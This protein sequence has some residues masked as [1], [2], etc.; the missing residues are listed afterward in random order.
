MARGARRRRRARR[1]RPR[2]TP[3]RARRR[4]RA[5]SR[6][7]ALALGGHDA[8]RE[9]DP[10]AARAAVPGRPRRSSAASA[11][12]SAGTRSRRCSRPTRSPRSSAATS[13]ATSRPRR[14]TRSA[15]TTSGTRPSDDAR[16][17]PRLHPGPLVAGHL[18]ARLPRGPAH[19]RSSCAASARR[20]GRRDGRSRS[21][22]HPWLMPDFW[23]FPT[24]SMGL[25][26]IMA[27]YQARF[28]K[29]L[30]GRGLADTAGRK[31]WAFLG[32]GETDEPE[33][34]GAI[35][36][37]GREHL[38][39][40]D[41]RRQLQ[42][43]AP[44][45]PGARQRQDHPGARDDLPRRGLE[46]HQGDLGLALGP[47]ARRR[48]RGPAACSAWRR[49]ST[50]TTRPTSR[51]TAPTCASTSSAP[52]PELREMVAHMT[53]EEIWALNR[54]GHDP[55]KVYAAYAAA[56]EHTG[57]A[58]GDPRQDDQGLRDGRGRRGPEHHP[59][60]EEDGRGRAAARSAT[61]SS[62]DAHRRAGPRRARST[63][64]PTTRRRWSYLRERRAALGGG[65]PA[66][67][68]DAPAAARCPELDAVRVASSRAPASARS[69]RRWRS[70]AILA[71]LLRDKKIGKH[72]VPI[73]PDE[74]RTFGMEGM[75][76]QLGIFS[77]VGQLYQPE[78]ADQLMF[79]REDK[80]GQVLQE[81]I[82][83]AGAFSSWIAAAHVVLQPRRADDPVLHLLLDV[84]LPAGRRPRL[85]RGRQPRAR[86]PARRHRGAHDAERRGPPARGRPLAHPQRDDPELRLLRPDVRL[87]G[88]RDRPG[89][90]AAHAGRA[91][92]RL[93]LPHAHERELP[94]PGDARG[95]ARR[96]SSRAC[97]CCAEA[98]GDGPQ[99]QL[100][101]SGT[102]LREVLAGAELL[103]EDFGVAADVW[104]VTSFTELRRDG[105]RGR[106]LE[107]AAPDRGAAGALGRRSRSQGTRGRWS[108][109]TDY[110]ARSPTASGPCVDRAATRCSAPTAS[111]AATTGASC[112][113]SSRS[114]ATT[115]RSP[116]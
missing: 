103:A 113:A 106:A 24:V 114:T 41:L 107:P 48:P 64:R 8:V 56:V 90:P 33:S 21:Y 49:P 35:S 112:G 108:P 52:Y 14:S 81:G 40:L 89:R 83:E 36:L 109:S 102:I 45:R 43:A 54:G 104:S 93:L 94:A 9:H 15:S 26:P 70:S 60:A 44:R 84:R 111:G 79:Y 87:R 39:N 31:V 46:R 99:V 13:P 10:A 50:A 72:V 6:G 23:Q 12:S 32:D 29:Y 38:D 76:R 75:F 22:P 80:Q 11:R 78:D 65:L 30:H 1:R 17:R 62:L 77:Q 82:N 20:S 86:L 63:S 105:H 101:G 25:G 5:A 47:A 51:A 71:T 110:C 85:G 115:S 28:M 97:T 74:S 19:A 68:R 42:P 69:R 67:R 53:D 96:G 2:R 4:A 57:A 7:A 58:D 116:R 92:G 18:R 100:L 59:P 16:R 55:Q 61:A 34:L 98:A 88:R 66:R 3:A 95:R 27:I 91:G 73:V 37:A